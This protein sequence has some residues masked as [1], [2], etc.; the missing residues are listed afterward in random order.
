MIISKTPLRISFFG[1]GT[2]FPEYFNANKSRI[3]GSTINKFVYSTNNFFR[4][5]SDINIKLFYSKV[6]MVKNL[7]EIKH[8]VVKKLLK[9]FRLKKNIELHFISDLPS[10][11]GLGSSSSF[12][13]GLSNLFFAIKNQRINK[14]LLARFAINFE[15]NYLKEYVGYQDQI[16]AS[17]GGF[18]SISLSKNNI[19]VENFKKNNDIKKI[20]NNSFIFN[21]SII[22]KANNIEKK[23]IDKIK[24]NIQYL[25]KINEISN[26]AYKYLKFKKLSECFPELLS[27][28]WNLKKKLHKN[29]TND[30]IEELYNYGISSGATSGKLLGAGSGGFIYF[31][32]PLKNQKKFNKRLK[33]AIKINFTNTGSQIIKI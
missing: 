32:V 11:S 4:P 29:I 20:E 26:E 22:R 1:G 2:D 19:T 23:K 6:E 28:S 5:T 8:N 25:D 13:V 21:T 10:F 15:R 30:K 9:K 18:N 24:S 27:Q 7:A 12:S 17:Y 33:D 31:Y 16:F 3:I 14:K